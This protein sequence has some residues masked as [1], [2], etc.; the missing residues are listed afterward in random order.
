MKK[1][2]QNLVSPPK[3]H[4]GYH[5]EISELLHRYDI[6]IHQLCDEERLE[7]LPIDSILENL[8]FDD[9]TAFEVNLEI[10]SE[11]NYEFIDN[12]FKDRIIHK[13][14]VN[15]NRQ[16]NTDADCPIGIHF[17]EGQDLYLGSKDAAD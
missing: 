14:P 15:D 1:S 2:N 9:D 11:T 6:D 12:S 7:D 4:I 17:D 3:T 13:T 16:S 8:N 10:E 5:N